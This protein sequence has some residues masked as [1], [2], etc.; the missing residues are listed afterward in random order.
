MKTRF[1]QILFVLIGLILPS[2]VAAQNG[3]FSTPTRPAFA[4]PKVTVTVEPSDGKAVLYSPLSARVAG[5]KSESLVV[6][7]LKISNQEAAAVTLSKVK[8]SFS[9]DPKVVNTVYDTDFSVQPN[10]TS[11]LNFNRAQNIHLPFPAPQGINIEL[12]FDGFTP[13]II[14]KPLVAHAN[15]VAQ[16]SYL[17][18]A[19]TTDLTVG[20]YWSGASGHPG[21]DQRFAYDMGVIARDPET[22]EWSSLLPGKSGE[23]NA[24]YR[25]WNRPVYAMADG[26]VIS[27][28]MNEPNNPA[29]GEKIT[30]GGGNSFSIQHGTEKALYAHLRAGTVTAQL[31]KPG[32]VVKAGD[33][34]GRAGNSGSSSA[35]HL[36]IHVTTLDGELRPLL[37]HN[38][39]VIERD[40][41]SFVGVGGPWVNVQGKALP[42][43]KNA[44]W[45][46]A[47]KPV[48]VVTCASL[49]ADIQEL[50]IDIADLKDEIGEAGPSQKPY[51]ANQIKAAQAKVAALKAEMEKR[52][53]QP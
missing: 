7:S 26:V 46:S 48:K 20:E 16:G 53:C 43:G 22:G 3:F 51:I 4:G 19:K 25:I 34:L 41:E 5:G 39:H 23:A 24:D 44:I 42:Y 35:P 2:A 47:T 36:H 17:F 6:L 21:S 1:I 9:G 13:V 30:S 28:K 45:P 37:F 32:A 14:S 40:G 10:K 8:V 49:R 29:P 50:E 38:I 15:P 33:L 11:T 52:G 27:C 12:T 18:P 31:C